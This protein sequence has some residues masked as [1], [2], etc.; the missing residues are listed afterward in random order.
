MTSSAPGTSGTT[1]TTGAAGSSFE[2]AYRDALGVWVQ[3]RRRQDERDEGDDG[4]HG[5]EEALAR[6]YELGRQALSQG[7][8]VV[9]LAAIHASALAHLERD[10]ERDV[11]RDHEGEPSRGPA[12]TRARRAQLFFEEAL[13]PF[14]MALRGFRE[15][16]ER[17]RG[18]N[19]DLT[20]QNA[21]LQRAREA[22]EAAA[23][24]LDQFTSSVS[25]DL[26]APARRV[27][28]FATMLMEDCAAQLD[29][30][31]RS[32]INRIVASAERMGHLIDDLLRLSR[33][34]RSEL[35]LQRCDVS[36]V[37]RAIVANLA[38]LD[39]DRH[40]DVVI[41]SGLIVEADL[42]LLTVVLENLIGNAWKFTSKTA[43]ARIEVGAE[44]FLGADGS[45]RIELFVKDNGAG[46]DSS[47]ASR[48]FV[49]FQRLHTEK[50]FEGTG[51]GLATV[52]RIVRRHGGRVRAESIPGQGATFAF[53]LG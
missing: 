3:T 49:P 7:L 10:V 43:A 8:G 14:E 32:H 4:D 44:S 40:V 38:A 1:G 33:V 11:E 36:A 45:D 28:G 29:D 48:L 24:E 39:P 18:M 19:E 30:V 25:H 9:E 22:A 47:Y 13:T 23:R 6:A 53:T 46:F 5:D 31:G 51:V 15:A 52:E 37:A 41:S 16:N 35:A 2:P 21:L 27:H 34:A 26:R 20:R 12:S 17:L 50:E 42:P